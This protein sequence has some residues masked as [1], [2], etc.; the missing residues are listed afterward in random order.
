MSLRNN[1]NNSGSSTCA[2]ELQDVSGYLQNS[3]NLSSHPH[4][5]HSLS[6]QEGR[7]SKSNDDPNESL[8]SPTTAVERLQR[9]NRPRV[10]LFRSFAAFWGFTVMGMNDSAYGVCAMTLQWKEFANLSSR[11]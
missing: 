8:P 9:W 7:Q 3:T 4:N 10:N 1:N 2:V 5:V 6:I 11:H